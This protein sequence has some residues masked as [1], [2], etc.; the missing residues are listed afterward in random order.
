MAHIQPDSWVIKWSRKDWETL[1]YMVKFSDYY[2]SVEHGPPDKRPIKDPFIDFLSN[3]FF[4]FPQIS[5]VTVINI[6]TT[7]SATDLP[8]PG[9]H[10]G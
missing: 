6:L 7:D 2:T 1:L 10:E 5:H 4:I 3:N 8:P 9:H